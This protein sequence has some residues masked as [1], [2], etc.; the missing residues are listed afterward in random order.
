MLWSYYYFEVTSPALGSFFGNSMHLT[1]LYG[2]YPGSI[3]KLKLLG[4]TYLLT[5]KI[6]RVSTNLVEVIEH[7][8]YSVELNV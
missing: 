3:E 4:A 7:Y 1:L 2:C 8:F 5:I 6:Y